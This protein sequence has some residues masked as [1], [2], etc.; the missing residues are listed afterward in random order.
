MGIMLLLVFQGWAYADHDCNP[1][2]VSY[3]G[4]DLSRATIRFE[5]AVNGVPYYDHLAR[6]AYEL[7]Y[8]T[9]RLV[10]SANFGA[11]CA[12]LDYLFT[13]VR[14]TFLKLEREHSYTQAVSPD[15]LIERDFR[16]VEYAFQR[17][18]QAL[19]GSGMSVTTTI[20]CESNQYKYRECPVPGPIVSANLAQQLSVASCQAGSSWGYHANIVWVNR[21]C[22]GHFRVTYAR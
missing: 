5:R 1:L 18:K 16:D 20:T 2:Q 21:G 10:N 4:R 8:E 19:G 12:E 17:V 9:D 6:Y 13:F 14:R 7:A 22:R 15:L 3:H 11:S